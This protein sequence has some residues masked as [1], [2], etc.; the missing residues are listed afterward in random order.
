MHPLTDKI[1]FSWW[2]SALV[3]GESFAPWPIYSQEKGPSYTL[4]PSGKREKESCSCCDLDRAPSVVQLSHLCQ[5]IQLGLYYQMGSL[6]FFIPQWNLRIIP[7]TFHL[8]WAKV[9]FSAVR[10]NAVCVGLWCVCSARDIHKIPAGGL[11]DAR[12]QS[13]WKVCNVCNVWIS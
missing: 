12:E 1:P 4:D 7:G 10:A 8:L 11:S 5:M 13:I 2:P 3:W 6:K 9:L